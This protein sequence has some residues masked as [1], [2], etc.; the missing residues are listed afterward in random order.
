VPGQ[1]K[2]VGFDD[3]RLASLVRPSLSTVRVPLAEVGAAAIDALVRRVEDPTRP[4]TKT[5]LATNL[6][7]R[8]SSGWA[9]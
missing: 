3:T 5:R 6:I 9:R 1:L 2:I 4:S 8:E 7:V